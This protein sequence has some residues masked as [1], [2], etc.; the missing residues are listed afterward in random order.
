MEGW[1]LRARRFAAGL[2]AKQVARAAGTSES[3]VAAY[4][5]GA[6]QPSPTVV[7]R[8]VAAVAAGKESPVHV[9]GLVTVPSAAAG[10]RAGIREGW[11]VEDLFRIVIECLNNAASLETEADRAIFFAR[12]STT[13]DPRWDSLLAGVVENQFRGAG[14]EPPAWTAEVAALD[15]VW[16]VAGIPG[17]YDRA[18]ESTPP[19]L[20]ARGIVLDGR[21]LESV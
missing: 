11:P 17:M 12:P 7:E 19:E 15:A 10:I 2:T 1:D 18:L 8:L 9:Y 20:K 4:E 6:K 13:G 21:S 5:R 14:Q 3:N 16:Y